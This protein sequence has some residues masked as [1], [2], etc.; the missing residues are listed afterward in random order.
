MTVDINSNCDITSGVCQDIKINNSEDILD[1]K[2]LV[3][4]HGSLMILAWIGF[5]STGIIISRWSKLHFS[6]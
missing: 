5:A 1:E 2:I 6:L 3:R 4:I